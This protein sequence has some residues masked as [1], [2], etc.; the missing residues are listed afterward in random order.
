[1]GNPIDA[2]FGD[3]LAGRYS[4]AI[5][6]LLAEADFYNLKRLSLGTVPGSPG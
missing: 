6:L 1:V 5:P 2:G 3:D 4:C